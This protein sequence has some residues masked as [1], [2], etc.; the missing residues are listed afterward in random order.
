MKI[1][2]NWDNDE[3]YCTYSKERINIGERYVLVEEECYDEVI[4]KPYKLEYAPS[5]NEDEIDY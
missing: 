3:L 1:L 2:T 4:E 5:E